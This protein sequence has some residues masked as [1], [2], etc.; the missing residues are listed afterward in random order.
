MTKYSAYGVALIHGITE[1][2]QI[3]SMSGPSL[4]LDTVDVTSHDGDGWE[5]HLPT[6]LRSG[7]V[8]FELLFDPDDASHAGLLTEMIGRE[9][10]A[11][12]VWFPDDAFTAWGFF[13]YVTGFSPSAPVEDALTGSVTLKLTGEPT[14]TGNYSP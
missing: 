3:R 4:T 2:A 12:E 8:T 11:F 6:I 7:T 9:A 14:L 1:I 10:E 5:E 13:A